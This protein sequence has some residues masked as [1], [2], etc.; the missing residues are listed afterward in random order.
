V[1]DSAIDVDLD[2]LKL[3]G[4]RHGRNA[5]GYDGDCYVFDA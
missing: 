2:T 4:F 3:L 5:D 1:R